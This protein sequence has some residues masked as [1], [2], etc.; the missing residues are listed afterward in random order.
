MTRVLRDE[1]RRFIVGAESEE[2]AA[3][4]FRAEIED[5]RRSG[6]LAEIIERMDLD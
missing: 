1:P 4:G 3:N 2:D 5:L 6:E